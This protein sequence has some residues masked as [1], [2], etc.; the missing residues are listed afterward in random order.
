MMDRDAFHSSCG[1][2]PLS[3]RPRRHIAA[4]RR[5]IAAVRRP[6]RPYREKVEE[7][8]K[9]RKGK[10]V[11]KNIVL[12]PCLPQIKVK[13]NRVLHAHNIHFQ[14]ICNFEPQNGQYSNL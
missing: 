13:Q 6:T 1:V 7:R 14:E 3:D 9:R 10:K 12:L 11:G 2:L 5:H 8:K 4:V